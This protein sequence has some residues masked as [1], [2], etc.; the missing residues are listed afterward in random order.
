MLWNI[1]QGFKVPIK[2]PQSV[3]RLVKSLFNKNA[4]TSEQAELSLSIFK[5]CNKA[6]H[7]ASVSYSEAISVIDSAEVLRDDYIRWLSWGFDNDWQHEELN[8]G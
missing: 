2:P 4:I 7:V 5:L 3:T 1:A 6:V 8:G